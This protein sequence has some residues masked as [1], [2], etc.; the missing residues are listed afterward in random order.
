MSIR[1]AHRTMAALS[2]AAVFA[3]PSPASA[4]AARSTLPP[5]PLGVDI[6][7]GV[8]AAWPTATDTF[9]ALNLGVPGIEFGGGVRFTGLWKKLFLQGSVHHWSD[10]GERV[11]VSEDGSV[12]PLDI[13]LDV[14]ATY[15]DA[16]VGWKE[17]MRN[18]AGRITFLTYAGAGAGVVRYSE[19][20]SFAQGDDDVEETKPGYHLLAGAEIP[21]GSMFAVAI[22]GR[23]RFVP[24]LLG[25]DGVSAVFEEDLFGGFTASVGVRIGFGG[26]VRVLPPVRPP[27][28]SAPATTG[29]APPRPRVDGGVIVESAPVFLLPD[30]TRTPLRTLPAGT[31]VRVLEE[32]GDWVRIEFRD[33]Q[34][35]ARVGFVQRK[36]V[37]VRQ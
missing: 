21:L 24:G 35:G 18:D 1:F 36:F 12:F 9:E 27:V 31:S 33:A 32:K 15:I 2:L 5:D 28:S 8:G 22:D 23:Y 29:A 11:F 6:F 20:S 34:Y 17:A 14:S 19:T 16:T 37:Q 3:C 25:E 7:A 13:R 4:Q 30:A 10:D 26:P